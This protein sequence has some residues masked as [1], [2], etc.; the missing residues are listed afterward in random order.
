MA[1][2][3]SINVDLDDPRIGKIA[4]VI[5]NKSAKKILSELAEAGNEGLSESELSQ[6]LKAPANTINYNIKKLESAG[7]IEKTKGYLWS[8]KGKRI[9]RYRVSNRKIVISPR[10]VRKYSGVLATMIVTGGIALWM[11]A[12]GIGE[13]FVNSEMQS[14]SQGMML[15]TAESGASGFADTAFAES[16]SRIGDVGVVIAENSGSISGIVGQNIWAWFLLGAW[17]ALLIFVV[18]SIWHE[19]LKEKKIKKE[20]DE[21]RL[22]D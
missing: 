7:L 10:S 17:S 19:R 5:S 13:S 20:N 4:D 9:F 14:G 15:K 12:V 3:S 11:K 1:G 8:E 16:A 18:Y 6:K 22:E 2:K 21:R